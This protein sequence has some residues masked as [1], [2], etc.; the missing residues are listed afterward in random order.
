MR[1]RV[2]RQ[3]LMM[4]THH[5][6]PMADIR[7]TLGP[8]PQAEISRRLRPFFML[9]FTGLRGRVILRSSP[10]PGPIP[11]SARARIRFAGV[12]SRLRHNTE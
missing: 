4:A 1:P 12:F 8:R 11:M 5:S 10:S 3:S 2:I 7:P 6:E 9:L